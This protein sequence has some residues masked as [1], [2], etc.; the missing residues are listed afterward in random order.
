MEPT[1][2]SAPSPPASE[3]ESNAVLPPS[4]APESQPERIS[5]QAV[6]PVDAAAGSADTEHAY[7]AEFEEDTTLPGEEELKE[8]ESADA[9]Y[10][11]RD[12]MS[13]IPF[14]FCSQRRGEDLTYA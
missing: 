13:P 1:R 3:S 9:D 8:I 6:E 14:P 7:W 4:S 2:D 12:R 11:A 5:R 10:S